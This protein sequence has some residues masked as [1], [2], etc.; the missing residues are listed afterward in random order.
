MAY[1]LVSNPS[2]A[3]SEAEAAALAWLE[4]SL[5]YESWLDRLRETGASRGADLAAAA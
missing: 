5:A 4:R 3:R 1:R 2:P